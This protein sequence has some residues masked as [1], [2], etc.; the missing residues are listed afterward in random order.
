MAAVMITE[1]P[2]SPRRRTPAVAAPRPR[3][4]RLAVVPDPAPAP[5]AR[6]ATT[7]R[8]VPEVRPVSAARASRA[9]FRRRRIG[10][11]VG[12]VVVVIMAGRAGAALGSASLAAPGRSPSGA[13]VTRYVVQ[14]GDSLW[15][16]AGH[17]APGEDPRAVVDALVRVRGSGPL[18]PGEVVRWQR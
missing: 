9:T 4:T 5:G 1:R 13:A 3:C 10:V 16:V 14:P 15:S 2:V 12:V 6:V 11:L 18:Q 8:V 7:A 17:I